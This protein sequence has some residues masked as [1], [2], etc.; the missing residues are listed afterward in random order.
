MAPLHDA[1]KGAEV[2]DATVRAGTQEAVVNRRALQPLTG[3]E[4]HIVKLGEESGALGLG[5]AL[6]LWDASVNGD[7][8]TGVSAVG[9]ARLYVLGAVGD[10]LVED[11]VLVAPQQ[12]PLLHGAVPFLA[13]GRILAALQVGKGYFVGSYDARPA[14]HLDTEVRQGEAPLHGEAAYGAAR[15][16]HHVAG[17]SAGSHL[18]HDVQGHVLGRDARL[19]LALYV[20]AH[21]L[22]LALQYAL[23]GQHLSHLAG[24]DAHCQ[25]AYCAVR[26]GVGV[27]ADNGHARQ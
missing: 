6:Q 14:T 1:G 18:R 11:G 17:G 27:A 12:A 26:A 13:L 7:A 25:G 16:L 19:Q 23:A 10:L 3:L 4:L 22:G 2:L 15:I 20:D 5:N 21:A 24:A 8:C 9:D